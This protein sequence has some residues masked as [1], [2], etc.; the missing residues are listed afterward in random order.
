MT[1]SIYD[2]S[3]ASYLQI[4]SGALNVMDKGAE[5]CVENGI[6]ANDIVSK[7]MC[8]DMLPFHFQVVSVVHH[9]LGAIRGMTKGE[10]G[11]PSGYPDT[12]YAGLRAMLQSA[13][14]ELAAMDK[15]TVNKLAGGATVFKFGD[16][17]MPFTN[18]NFVLSFSHPNVY[19]H[20]TTTYD[21]L[22]AMGVNIG[23]RDFMGR[24]RMGV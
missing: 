22:R 9:S 1:T 21:I 13:Y 19:F 16:I 8:D 23:K 2:M 17:E 7:R 12:D 6:D 14:D 5:Y 20:A 3:V 24:T 4:I 18:E 10:F 11:P 15:D